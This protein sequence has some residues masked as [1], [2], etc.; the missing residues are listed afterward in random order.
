MSP[1]SRETIDS[2][3]SGGAGRRVSVCHCRPPSHRRC[4]LCGGVLSGRTFGYRVSFPDGGIREVFVH[5]DC[6]KQKRGDAVVRS[7]IGRY[8]LLTLLHPQNVGAAGR[9]ETGGEGRK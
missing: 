3:L 6:L 7:T 2:Y 1:F 8:Q 5:A 4:V 9:S